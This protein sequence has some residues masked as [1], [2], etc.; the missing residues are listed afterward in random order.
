MLAHPAIVCG[1]EQQLQMRHL[2]RTDLKL[3]GDV[4]ACLVMAGA[5]GTNPGPHHSIL[6]LQ[7]H[8]KLLVGERGG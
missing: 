7:E 2:E 3:E 4:Q 8:G 5:A 1:R 6:P